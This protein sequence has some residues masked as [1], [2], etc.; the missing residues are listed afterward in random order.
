MKL[1]PPRTWHRLYPT[2]IVRWMG[3][4]GWSQTEAIAALNRIGLKLARSTVRSEL[5]R[6]KKG[7][8]VPKLT[9][10]KERALTERIGH[11]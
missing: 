1:K 9:G 7:I 4:R 2:A 6:G 5:R 3:S 8:D 10:R 11:V